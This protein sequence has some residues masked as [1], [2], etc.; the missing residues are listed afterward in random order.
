MYAD[1]DMSTYSR[2]KAQTG[3]ERARHNLLN[4]EGARFLVESWQEAQGVSQERAEEMYIDF[5]TQKKTLAE[6]RSENEA[7]VAE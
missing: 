1:N 2:E 5:Y 4:D 6:L 3:E 7:L